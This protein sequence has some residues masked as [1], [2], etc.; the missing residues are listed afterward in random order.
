MQNR[1]LRV[2]SI[3]FLSFLVLGMNLTP[4]AKFLEF[5][6]SGDKFAVFAGPIIDAATLRTCEFKKL[7]LRH[8]ERYYTQ[9][10][11]YLQPVGWEEH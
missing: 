2:G 3:L 1:P 11:R 4:S 8:S 5:N 10:I 9:K 6:L 7:I